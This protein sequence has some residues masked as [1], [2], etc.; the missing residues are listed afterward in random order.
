MKVAI[1]HNSHAS[2]VPS[3]EDVV[4]D[5]E[6][7]T[8]SRQPDVDVV[9]LD[10][11]NDLEMQRPMSTI[12]A[13]VAS[14]FGLGSA[15]AIDASIDLVH[16]HNTFPFLGTRWLQDVG[17]P[18]VHT[19][20]N[21][22][23]FCA[24]GYLF[25]DGRVC[26]EC[27]D[28]NRWSGVKH[29]CYRDSRLATAPVA[30]GGR[31]GAGHN[32]LLTRADRVLVLSR[33]SMQMM[34]DAGLSPSKLALDAHFLP[35]TLAS[36]P[37]SPT[38]HSWVF[39]G[40]LSPEKGVDLLVERWPADVPLTIIGDGPSMP[41]VAAVAR[42]KRFTVTGSL[43]RSTVI[44]HVATAV[45]LVA[46]SLLYETFG[47]VYLEALSVGVPVLAF[48]PNVIADAVVRDGTG[49]VARWDS[50]DDDLRK[51]AVAFLNLREHCRAVFEARY[52][53]RAFVERRLAM[54]RDLIAEVRA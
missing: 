4:V 51:A 36:R 28:G 25:R 7:E 48:Q 10:V 27:P 31:R 20:H 42:T 54:Y 11:K 33:R 21:Y 23:A 18:V 3:G 35:D 44:D 41:H 49:W 19:V 17:A 50:L 2:E 16:V 12:R 24:N 46:P 1:V 14:A 8:L 37:T 30:F 9:L 53:E 13:G 39:V 29:G 6:Y 47:L 34:I 5:A 26:T 45:G 22:R 15:V 43:D 32:P 52:S 40:R 38:S